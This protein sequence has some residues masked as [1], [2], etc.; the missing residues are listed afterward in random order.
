MPDMPTEWNDYIG[1][2]SI[3]EEESVTRTLKARD[4]DIQIAETI[5]YK[6]EC[7]PQQCMSNIIYKICIF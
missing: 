4:G 1:T 5:Q 2:I 7:E 6:L 3:K